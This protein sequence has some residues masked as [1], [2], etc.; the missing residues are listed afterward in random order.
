MAENKCKGY[1]CESCKYAIF[2]GGDYCPGFGGCYTPEYVCECKR[3]EIQM[4][5]GYDD[6][7]FDEVTECQYFESEDE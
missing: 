1:L 4:S 6:M 3:E 5:E 7:D 2:E